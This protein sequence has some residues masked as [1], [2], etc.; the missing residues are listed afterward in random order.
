M[1]THTC[2]DTRHSSYYYNWQHISDINTNTTAKETAMGHWGT[3]PLDLQ[4]FIF[5]QFTL[6]YTKSDSDYM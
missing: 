1:M 2:R 4:Q 6:T 5:L 3:C